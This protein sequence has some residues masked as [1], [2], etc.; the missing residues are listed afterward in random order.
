MLGTPGGKRT[1]RPVDFP[2]RATSAS[3]DVRTYLHKR[4]IDPAAIDDPCSNAYITTKGIC[5]LTSGLSSVSF[6]VR[7]CQPFGIVRFAL[8]WGVDMS[9]HLY[10]AAHTSSPETI[11]ITEGAADALAAFTSGYRGISILGSN[12]TERR[13]EF[14]AGLI[15]ES[16]RPAFFIPDNDTAGMSAVSRMKKHH[17]PCKT[18]YLPY[19]VKDLCELTAEER[20]E[21]LKEVT[22]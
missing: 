13:A 12:L 17:V 1:L 5:F 7:L 19:G 11:I 10:D 3:T 4:N 8:P 18:A 6:T 14:L 21:F 2:K 22:S 15:K 16:N 20:K 9:D